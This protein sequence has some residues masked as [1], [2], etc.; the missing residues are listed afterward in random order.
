MNLKAAP[1][2]GFVVWSEAQADI[3]RNL[4]IWGECSRMWHGPFLF[5]EHPTIADAMYAPVCTRFLTYDVNLTGA[6]VGYCA[7]ILALPAMVEWIAAAKAEPEAVPEP[8]FEF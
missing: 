1:K 2:A 8:D 6:A 5:G 3:D 4:K 7:R